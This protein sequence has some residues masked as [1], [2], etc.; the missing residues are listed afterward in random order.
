MKKPFPF[1]AVLSRVRRERGFANAH[2]FY[3]GCGGRRALDLSFAN[4]MAL[5]RGKSLPKAR[6]LESIVTAL[7]LDENSAQ[8]RELV[9][10]Y[11][12]SLLGSDV[13]LRGLES[14]APSPVAESAAD[15]AS[16]QAQRQRSAQM[17]L[18]QW[19]AIATDPD[20]YRVHVYL[21]NTPDWSSEAEIA[22]AVGQAPSKTRAILKKLAAA[23]VI[24]AS[25]GR[26][27]SPFAY[28]YLQTFPANPETLHL[29]A[30]LLKT[31][32][33]FAGPDAKLLR[34]ANVTTRFSAAGLERYFQRLSD[35]VWLSGVYGD[36]EKTP[37]S[38]V[39]FVDA[40]IFKIFD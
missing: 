12:V 15:E 32:E 36:A 2:S 34:R 37:D 20:A 22:R 39:C 28:K 17:T 11:L 7:G 26:A 40:R 29:K 30:G 31:R 23:R 8:R 38:D 10:A 21:V 13:L 33:G 9:R 24:E 1:A 4:Y 25:S 27:R 6:R 19:K 14:G 35:A 3:K 16:R 5:E 18:Q